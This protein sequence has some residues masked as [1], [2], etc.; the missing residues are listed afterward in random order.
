[1]VNI[2]LKFPQKQTTVTD[3]E[4]R[5]PA[6]GM[7][8]PVSH[9]LVWVFNKEL[10]DYTF[11]TN[12]KYQDA[13]E[14]EINYQLSKGGRTRDETKPVAIVKL[15]GNWLRKKVAIPSDVRGQF[16]FVKMFS[17]DKSCTNVDI[18]YIGLSA[19]H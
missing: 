18:E 5:R 14:I 13:N 3:F 15:T 17:R 1:V 7:T 12:V 10:P 11:F 19:L 2:T 6:H 8:N 9:A 16:A 4:L